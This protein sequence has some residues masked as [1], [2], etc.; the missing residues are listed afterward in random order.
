[1]TVVLYNEK[2]AKA[3]ANGPR[4][5]STSWD[6]STYGGKNTLVSTLYSPATDTVAYMPNQQ[7]RRMLMS[8]LQDSFIE[9]ARASKLG[10]WKDTQ[11]SGAFHMLSCVQLAAAS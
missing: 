3:F 1:M 8:D 9:D 4:Q 10:L 2:V 7:L 11:S 6:P 5:F